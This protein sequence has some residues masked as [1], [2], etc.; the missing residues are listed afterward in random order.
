VNVIA[1]NTQNLAKAGAVSAAFL[2]CAGPALQRV[3]VFSHSIDKNV[4]SKK[5]HIY[6]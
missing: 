2:D 4:I 3:R 1:S 5:A 6:K